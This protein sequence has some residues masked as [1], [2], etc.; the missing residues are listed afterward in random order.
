[1]SLLPARFSR[2]FRR[3]GQGARRRAGDS[4]VGLGERLQ[5]LTSR[6]QPATRH[7]VVGITSPGA[8]AEVR[9]WVGTAE[10]AVFPDTFRAVVADRRGRRTA[11]RVK[12]SGTHVE[13]GCKGVVGTI[14]IDEAALTGAGPWEVAVAPTWGTSVGEW[15]RIGTHLRRGVPRD[16]VPLARGLAVV[17]FEG[18]GGLVVQRREAARDVR[19][20]EVRPDVDGRP[21]AI[22]AGADRT[23]LRAYAEVSPAGSRQARHR[24]P[25]RAVEDA[26]TAVRLPAPAPDAGGSLSLTL[27]V[28]LD[29][30]LWP[31]A[32]PGA[33]PAGRFDG[34]DV[35]VEE[36]VIVIGR[37]EGATGE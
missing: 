17:A 16:G 36:G 12:A 3:L 31:V 33:T 20:V 37:P 19:V 13:D 15:S 35:Q 27:S 32:V 29:G 21:E 18:T 28:V 9:V 8:R 23:A 1:M 2:T 30:V 4:L 22:I 34:L 6:V 5:P 14:R 24:L 11:V 25:F 7:K 26:L 10:Y